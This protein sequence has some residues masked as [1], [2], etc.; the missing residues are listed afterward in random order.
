MG[1][2]GNESQKYNG[3][4][5]IRFYDDP[6]D[7]GC[8]FCPS[9]VTVENWK[10]GTVECSR[11]GLVLDQILDER[12]EWR[13]YARDGGYDG[14][15]KI[16]TGGVVKENG[17][18]DN[19]CIGNGTGT[20]QLNKAQR[21]VDGVSSKV[22]SIEI[23]SYSMEG[24]LRAAPL[25]FSDSSCLNA[26]NL[27]KC[28]RADK[29]YLRDFVPLQATCAYYADK[30][31]FPIS[32][33]QQAFGVHVTKMDLDIVKNFIQTTPQFKN[34]LDKD[35]DVC[36]HIVNSCKQD[37]SERFKLINYCR[38]LKN[39]LKDTSLSHKQPRTIDAAIV[40]FISDE[41]KIQLPNGILDAYACKDTIIKHKASI[42]D[43][44]KN[45]SK[46]KNAVVTHAC[47]ITQ[48]GSK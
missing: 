27:Y 8:P 10:E 25:S 38:K 7:G 30:K 32:I 43:I 37:Q 15:D 23:E 35:L 41:M 3:V 42:K 29:E 12:A 31:S 6:S 18:L 47:T 13:V 26:I 14:T 22:K 17:K 46:K 39:Q 4:F 1:Y 34:L 40:A 11:C 24:I 28:L 20:N 21:Q 48:C 5:P 19:L 2:Y 45:L 9:A 33:L 36:L 16:R 44:L